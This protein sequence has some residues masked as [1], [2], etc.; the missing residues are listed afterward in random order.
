MICLFDVNGKSVPK[1]KGPHAEKT[2][3]SIQGFFASGK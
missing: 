2:S 3:F 1:R